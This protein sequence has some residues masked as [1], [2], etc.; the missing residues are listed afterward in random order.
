MDGLY[1]GIVG[2]TAADALRKCIFGSFD[3][4]FMQRKNDY[5]I[6]ELCL[7][8]F[9][10]IMVVDLNLEFHTISVMEVE[11]HVNEGRKQT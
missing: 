2:G 7:C 8:R 4:K 3:K 11:E 6:K 1:R 9:F 10:G 5:D